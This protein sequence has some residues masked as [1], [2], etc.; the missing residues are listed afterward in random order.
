MKLSLEFPSLNLFRK[1]VPWYQTCWFNSLHRRGLIF[2]GRPLN[3]LQ[4]SWNH[5]RLPLQSLPKWLQWP[6]PCRS[7]GR[8]PTF[9]AIQASLLLH[10][11]CL[12]IMGKCIPTL[13]FFLQVSG[14]LECRCRINNWQILLHQIW[15]EATTTLCI[16]LVKLQHNSIFYRHRWQVLTM[17]LHHFCSSKYHPLPLLARRASLVRMVTKACHIVH[18]I[19]MLR[20][21]LGMLYSVPALCLE[22]IISGRSADNRHLIIPTHH[23]WISKG[24]C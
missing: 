21:I 18:I 15:V 22:W 17:I 11:H 19:H 12:V 6:M 9:Q 13:R 8:G 20:V 3:T 24:R 23:C 14:A 1:Q 5:H 16:T 10:R 2:T 4:I 7:N